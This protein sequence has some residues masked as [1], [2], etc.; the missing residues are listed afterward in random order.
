[1]LDIIDIPDKTL[2]RKLQLIHLWLTKVSDE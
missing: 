2:K 1:M